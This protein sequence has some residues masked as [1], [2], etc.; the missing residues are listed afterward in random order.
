MHTYAAACTVDI[1]P[2]EPVPLAGSEVRT[3]A[4]Q[5]IAD[6]LEANALVLRQGGRPIV[7]VSVD[8]VFVGRELRSGVLHRLGS[9]VDDES[10]FFT[11]SHT[12]FAPATDDRRPRLGRMD[13]SYLDRVCS[14]VSDLVLRLLGESLALTA[15][16]YSQGTADHAVNRRLRAP[17]HLSRRG[18]LLGSVVAAPNLAGPRDESVHLL[19]ISRHD[20]RPLAVIWSYACHPVSFPEPLKV[21]ADYPGRVR[22]RLRHE[23]GSDLPVLFWQGYAGDIRPRELGR[24]TSLLGRVK[25]VLLGPRFGRFTSGEWESWADSLAGRVAQVAFLSSRRSADGPIRVHRLTRPLG[26]FVLGASEDRRV[27]FHGLMLSKDLVVVGVSAEV[28]TEYGAL[29]SQVFAGCLPIP[30]G[31]IDDVYGY[32]P[33]ARMLKEGGYEADWFLEPFALDGPLHPEIERHCLSALRELAA[34]LA[35]PTPQYR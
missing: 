14:Q 13:A 9:T 4:F 26:D 7:L 16:E 25:R 32:M 18:L 10:L 12:H 33:T 20:G 11:A 1:T 6:R 24:S 21:S 3:A 31:Y 22:R 23:F 27:T 5:G 35:A 34:A 15:S 19:R 29:L 17:W 2:E 28:V 30:V 8:L